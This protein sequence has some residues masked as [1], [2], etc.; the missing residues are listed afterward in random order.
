MVKVNLPKVE[1]ETRADLNVLK[2]NRKDR[3]LD[4]TLKHLLSLEEK[5]QFLEKRC[6]QKENDFNELLGM[7]TFS[8]DEIKVLDDLTRDIDL[9]DTEDEEYSEHI[10]SIRVKLKRMNGD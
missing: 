4:Q 1:D 8:Q 7:G 5:N 10:K 9:C 6:T 3:A 2:A